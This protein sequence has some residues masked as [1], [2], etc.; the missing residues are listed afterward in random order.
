M[1]GGDRSKKNRLRLLR[2]LPNAQ[3]RSEGAAADNA[4]AAKFDV[5]ELFYTTDWKALFKDCSA[6]SF[7]SG[8][9]KDDNTQLAWKF[10]AVTRSKY[11]PLGVRAMYKV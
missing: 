10:E 2:S 5:I 11:Y 1:F 8:F 4:A 3:L 9:T 6:D 7:M